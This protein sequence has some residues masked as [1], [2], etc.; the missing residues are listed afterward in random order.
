M[1][2]F[3]KTF[4]NAAA[5]YEKSRPLYPETLYED[6]FRYQPVGGSSSVLEIGVGTGKASL[7][8]LETRCKWFGLEPGAHLAAVAQNKFRAYEN[9]ALEEKTLQELVCPPESFDLIYAA[10]AF[11]WIPE[12]YGYKRVYELLKSGGTFARFAYHAGVDRRRPELAEEI[13][14][15]YR[16][17]FGSTEAPK[18]FNEEDAKKLAD[19][20]A[21][22]GFTDPVWQLYESTKD[23]TAEE[24]LELLTTYPDHMKLAEPDRRALFEG[25]YN[26][27]RHHGGIITVYYTVDLELARKP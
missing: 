23:F 21:H 24:Y 17:Y 26:A 27:I 3:E 20:A 9:A 1:F 8:V 18:A 6:L 22:Y 2:A 16:K 11:H 13:Q 25:I 19:L 10:T 15:L 5:N 4:D 14:S 7:P 12:E